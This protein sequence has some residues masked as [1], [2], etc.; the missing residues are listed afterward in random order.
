MRKAT[1]IY[2]APE[3]DSEVV[4][5]NGVRFFDGETVELNS[6]DHG[7][8]LAKLPDNPHFEVELGEDV[9]DEKPKRGPG[10][11]RREEVREP[12]TA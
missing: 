2:H 6:N 8:L 10:R 11:P 4:H 12:V 5:T 9:P 1:A 7:H 3:G